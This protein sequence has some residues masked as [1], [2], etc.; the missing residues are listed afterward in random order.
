MKVIKNC[1]FED[2]DVMDMVD[3]FCCRDNGLCI[4]DFF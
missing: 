3:P 2:L 4:K 1:V